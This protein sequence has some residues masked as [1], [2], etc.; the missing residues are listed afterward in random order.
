MLVDE[1]EAVAPSNATLTTAPTAA[2][3]VAETER[4]QFEAKLELLALDL[5]KYGASC[6]HLLRNGRCARDKPPD[7]LDI[8]QLYRLQIELKASMGRSLRQQ[9]EIP[10]VSFRCLLICPRTTPTLRGILQW[11]GKQSSALRP[12]T[13]TSSSVQMCTKPFTM[14]ARWLTP[15]QSLICR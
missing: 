14:G 10:E 3:V 7:M 8:V 13:S 5:R 1:Q 4:Y 6:A 15:V 2:P 9:A 12:R 11:L